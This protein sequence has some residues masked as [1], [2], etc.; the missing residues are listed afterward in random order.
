MTSITLPA[1]VTLAH[2]QTTP[3]LDPTRP[4]WFYVM[5]GYGFSNAT[6][7]GSYT[8]IA[9]TLEPLKLLPFSNIAPYPVRHQTIAEPLRQES[10]TSSNQRLFI[11]ETH[12]YGVTERLLYPFYTNGVLRPY[13]VPFVEEMAR[14]YPEY[15][16]MTDGV[17]VVIFA[18]SLHSLSFEVD[19]GE[20]EVSV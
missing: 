20:S 1:N 3:I 4:T 15:D 9:K 7:Y 17:E 2:R 18:R 16:G 11:T 12:R 8:F 19:E 6:W 5:G 10:D 14:L 13:D